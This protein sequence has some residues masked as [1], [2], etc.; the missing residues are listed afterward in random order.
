[1]SIGYIV[2]RFL[3]FV[4]VVWAAATF[5]FFLPRLGGINPIRE[6]LIAQSSLSGSVQAG[7]EDMIA[8]IRDQVWS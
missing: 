8:G 5:N 6:K 2:R 7:L 1:M 3:I 4:V